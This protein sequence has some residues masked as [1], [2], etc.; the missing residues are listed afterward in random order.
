MDI[1]RFWLMN[2]SYF[3]RYVESE[4]ALTEKEVLCVLLYHHQFDR[5][6]GAFNTTLRRSL[7]QQRFIV[8]M[9]SNYDECSN[10]YESLNSLDLSDG[11][12]TDQDEN[13]PKYI[14]A[15]FD[16]KIVNVIKIEFAAPSEAMSGN[17]G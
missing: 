13:M 14:Q 16:G 15:C 17:W 5:G 3:V 11:C 9:S 4:K 10:T 6:C 8:K 1:I 12:G 7:K 2:P